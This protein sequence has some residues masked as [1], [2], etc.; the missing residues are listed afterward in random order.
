MDRVILAVMV[1]FGWSPLEIKSSLLILKIIAAPVCAVRYYRAG[2]YRAPA[3]LVGS[4][5]GTE[6]VTLV[7]PL[8][9]TRTGVV[10]GARFWGVKTLSTIIF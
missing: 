1:L 4:W 7:I 3:V 8:A 9:V 2:F 5:I 6:L 10:T